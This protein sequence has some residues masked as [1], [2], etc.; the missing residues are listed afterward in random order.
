MTVWVKRYQE[1]GEDNTIYVYYGNPNA[2]DASDGNATF[3]FYEDWESGTYDTTKWTTDGTYGTHFRVDSGC[4][5]Q[6]TYGLH[7]LG[8]TEQRYRTHWSVSTFNGD[9]VLT[10]VV[11]STYNNDDMGLGILAD[12][13]YCGNYYHPRGV[14]GNPPSSGWQ[15]AT[16]G[17]DCAENYYSLSFPPE[18]FKYRLELRKYG[19]AVTFRIYNWVTGALMGSYTTTTSKTEGKIFI[20]TTGWDA[21]RNA[22]FD[23]IY[24]RKYTDPEPTVSVGEEEQYGG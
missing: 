22:W 12:G 13:N 7:S 8:R 16:L 17:I 15:Y 18:G 20:T 21:N 1:N 24:L 9:Y 2:G 5:I 14:Y 6:G 3:M 23:L 10:S 19:S 4:P 11:Y